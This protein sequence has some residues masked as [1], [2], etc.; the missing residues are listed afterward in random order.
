M[1]KMLSCRILELTWCV[2]ACA[3][4]AQTARNAGIFYSTLYAKTMEPLRISNFGG[5]ATGWFLRDVNGDNQDDA[6]VY[7]GKGSSLGQWHVALS[8][9]TVFIHPAVW[10][11]DS[12]ALQRMKPLM[13]DVNGDGKQ[14]AV[15]FDPLLGRWKVAFSNGS[16]FEPP[17]QFTE[18][19]G[20]GSSDQFLA[21]V[22]GDGKDD[23]VIVFPNWEGG[24]W[25]VGL[26]NGIN[27]FDSFTPWITSFGSGSSQRFVGDV[28]GDGADDALTCVY[29]TG[30]WTVALANP[31]AQQFGTPSV[32]ATAFGNFTAEN[33]PPAMDGGGVYDIDGD[34]ASDIVYAAAEEGEWWVAYSDRTKFGP[35]EHRWITGLGTVDSVNRAKQNPPPVVS[36]L[37][38]SISEN[39]GYACI[40]DEWG[41]W[42]AVNNPQKNRT[43]QLATENTY[44]AWR[45]SYEPQL[46]GYEGTYDSGDPVIN[47]LQIQMIHDA[48]FTYIMFDIT[49]GV[50]D[51]VDSRAKAFMSRVRRWNQTISPHQHKIYV[52]IAL[53]QTR[54]ISDYSQYFAQLESEAR[55]AWTEWF[56]PY[57]DVWYYLDGKPMVVHMQDTANGDLYKQLPTYTGTRTYIDR[58]TN[59]WMDIPEAN[60]YGWVVP[61]ANPYHPEM[62][63]VQPGFWN[64]W[65]YYDRENGNRYRNHWRRVI[66]YQP[67]SVFV[68]SFNETWEHNSVEP[69]YM[70][71]TR[72]PH[73]GITMW[74]DAYGER[75]D[76]YYW[77]MTKQYMKLYMEGT[78]PEGTYFQEYI[79]DGQYGPIYKVHPDGCIKQNQPPHQSPVLLVPT[80]FLDSVYGTPHGDPNKPLAWWPLDEGVGMTVLDRQNGYVGQMINMSESA[81]EGRFLAG[82]LCFDGVDDSL[83]IPPILGEH[84]TIS[85]WLRTTDFGYPSGE[86]YQGKGLVD[87]DAAGTADD[88]GITLMGGQVAFGVGNPDTTIRSQTIVNDDQWHHVAVTRNASSGQMNLY[89]DGRMERTATGP[90]GVK[91]AAPVIRV[92]AIQ[93]QG[94]N[95]FFRGEI[96]D[97]RFYSTVL[98]D[99]QIAYLAEPCKITRDVYGTVGGDWTGRDGIQDC[100]IDLADFFFLSKNWRPTEPE[101]LVYEAEEADEIGGPLFRNSAAGYSGTGYLVFLVSAAGERVQWNISLAEPFHGEIFFRYM[102][103]SGT[104]RVMDLYLDGVFYTTVLFSPTGSW[105]IWAETGTPVHLEVGPH[106]IRLESTGTF[107]PYLDKMMLRTTLSASFAMDSLV[108]IAQNWLLC[109]DPLRPDCPWPF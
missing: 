21:D 92:G 4:T 57:S 98:G 84:F 33:W 88:F 14:D 17:V 37:G 7:Y 105:E 31:A 16:G 43:L 36:F 69:S 22:N 101:D 90:A 54:Q 75:M 60:S 10:L 97:L 96:D 106:S 44:V 40:V 78:L 72:Q 30:V 20:V 74:T 80:G 26:S 47:D 89:V 6:V 38:G 58:F 83:Q 109:Y 35:Y 86:W 15:L 12:G 56:L 53:G 63:P 66:E 81:W 73:P 100:M 68:V 42:F 9:G 103:G 67:E 85:F 25:Y 107:G 87:A 18:G 71:N 64:S 93:T 23:A 59:R 76:N 2:F 79:S 62:M 46:P 108:E 13:G 11:A 102:D 28:N 39:C 48:G 94:V 24:K 77:E 29:S 32:W 3:S 41:R 5:N 104:E 70:F 50:H 19:N 1:G 55:R 8:N 65:T 34:G 45:C 52:T 49:N 51:W 82:C 95:Q 91:Q 61:P 27:S 99:A